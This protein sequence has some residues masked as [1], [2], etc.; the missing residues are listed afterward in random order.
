MVV[1]SFVYKDSETNF[2][3]SKSSNGS[4]LSKFSFLDNE[5]C[6]EMDTPIEDDTIIRVLREDDIINI[7]LE[8]YVIGVVA[9]EMPASFNI[10][11]LK[12][13]ALAARTYALYRKSKN[14]NKSYDV[15]DDTRTQVYIDQDKMLSMWDSDFDK[16]YNK[17]S[18]AVNSTKGEVITYNGK[19][20]ES[21]YF[22]MSSGNTQDAIYA[23]NEERDYLKGV[24]S[25]YEDDSINGFLVT[26]T[27][28]E[29]N[30]IKL[31]SLSCDNLTIDEIKYNDEGYVENITLCGKTINGMT[32][33]NKVGL[34]S[35]SFEIELG[36]TV[37][38][39]TK[40]FGHGV[41]MS[42]YGA[43]GYAMNGYTYDEI[44]KHYYT[45]VDISNLK[46]V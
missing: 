13:Q 44:I 34:R 30:I 11:A 8:E 29:A 16:Y 23:F 37:T 12:A 6:S 35:T 22:A 46:N 10:E 24:S 26:R 28:E 45:G 21:L 19:I 4:V 27:F 41:G 2:Y 9:G 15:T 7:P 32:F 17:I 42:Q 36:D 3:L 14:S 33:V 20:I 31:F 43:N 5:E 25:I 40:G 38:I 18:S 39:T 1:I